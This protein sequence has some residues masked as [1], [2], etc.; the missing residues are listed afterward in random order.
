MDKRNNILTFDG[1]NEEVFNNFCKIIGLQPDLV[2][3][4]LINLSASY[5]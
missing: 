1:N 5:G 3:E 4:K 2:K